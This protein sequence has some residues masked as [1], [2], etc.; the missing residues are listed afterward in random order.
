MQF[1][2]IWYQDPANDIFAAAIS[3]NRFTFIGFKQCSTS[4]SAKYILLNNIHAACLYSTSLLHY[5]I[6]EGQRRSADNQVIST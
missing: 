4:K 2:H 6:Q 5:R 3:L 1:R